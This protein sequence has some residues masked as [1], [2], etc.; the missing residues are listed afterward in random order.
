MRQLEVS[1]I[2]LSHEWKATIT[3]APLT[4]Q[5]VPA[6]EPTWHRMKP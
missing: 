4:E 3:P 5:D 2:L 6:K 1:R